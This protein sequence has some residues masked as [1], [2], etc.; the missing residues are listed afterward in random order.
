MFKIAYKVLQIAYK[1]FQ[2]A[3]K[4]F[5][6]TFTVFQTLRT[7]AAAGLCVSYFQ[8]THLEVE[9]S[10]SIA[11]R[12]FHCPELKGGFC[13]ALNRGSLAVSEIVKV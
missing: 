1:G 12:V 10:P 7:H 13:L 6:I 5:Q 8:L 4:V 2:I 11:Y 3:Y 9:L